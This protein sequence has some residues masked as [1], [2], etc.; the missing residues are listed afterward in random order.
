MPDDTSPS[1]DRPGDRAP[2][3]RP[4]SAFSTASLMGDD[5]PAKVADAIE[6]AVAGVGDRVVRPLVLAARAVVFGILIG[7]M[8]SVLGVLCAVAVVRVLDNYAFS[9]RVWA[10]EAVVGGALTLLGL[11]F[12][13]KRRSGAGH[14]G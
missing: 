1:A 11:A 13:S 12:W 9:H 2:G 14:Q 5:W 7:A 4:A 8:V 6:G 3:E 10:S